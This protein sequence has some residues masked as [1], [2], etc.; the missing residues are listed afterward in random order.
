M[1]FD[2][3]DLIELLDLTSNEMTEVLMEF[4]SFITLNSSTYDTSN[5]MLFWDIIKNHDKSNIFHN[6]VDSNAMISEQFLNHNK[7]FLG[8]SL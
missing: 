4:I 2:E 3:L 7:Y 6:K 5:Q 1:Q 8:N